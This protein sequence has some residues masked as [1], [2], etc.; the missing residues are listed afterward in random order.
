MLLDLLVGVAYTISCDMLPVL[1]AWP[2]RIEVPCLRGE[3][4]V[5]ATC[6]HLRHPLTRH[7]QDVFTPF[8][9]RSCMFQRIVRYTHSS[10]TLLLP[11]GRLHSWHCRSEQRDACRS[12]YSPF[13][14]RRCGWS[15]KCFTRL[16]EPRKDVLL[17]KITT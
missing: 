8:T 12:T 10:D 6:V 3:N 1:R 7:L 4:A 5:R 15:A 14:F 2:K 13:D 17:N 16:N 9:G 11:I